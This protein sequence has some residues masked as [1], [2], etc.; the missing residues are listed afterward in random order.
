MAE[1]NQEKKVGFFKKTGK[2][3]QKKLRNAQ[4]ASLLLFILILISIITG[5][6]GYYLY[7]PAK[8][9]YV[10][11]NTFHDEYR[12]LFDYEKD[13]EEWTKQQQTVNEAEEVY[14][15]VMEKYTT[16]S[17]PLISKYAHIDSGF[18]KL[19]IAIIIV[20]PFLAI[21]LMFIGAPVNFLF[22]VANIFIVVPIKAIVY[23]FNSLRPEKKEKA[24]K[25]KH[26][27]TPRQPQTL[28]EAAN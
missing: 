22:A 5:I 4:R 28:E 9:I 13:S 18:L 2:V 15:A 26:E 27:K 21:G 20:L 1:K 7:Q 24:K 10:A 14:N 8:E 3:L 17:N 25:R 6:G 12:D 11:E 23:L 19:I 16:D